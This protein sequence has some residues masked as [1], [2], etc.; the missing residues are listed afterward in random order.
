MHNIGG[1]FI[2][3]SRNLG[4]HFNYS[5]NIYCNNWNAC[6]IAGS[7][8]SLFESFMAFTYWNWLLPGN[9]NACLSQWTSHT[10]YNNCR[11]L[12]TFLC[13]PFVHHVIHRDNKLARM[14]WLS[15]QSSEISLC[16]FERPTKCVN[17]A[18]VRTDD[19]DTIYMYKSF[20]YNRQHSFPFWGCK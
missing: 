14:E 2:N 17:Q 6:F 15:I 1:L 7:P 16:A 13:E 19:I 8:V 10:P 3:S 11:C 5:I 9:S 12:R 20:P 4:I 18:L